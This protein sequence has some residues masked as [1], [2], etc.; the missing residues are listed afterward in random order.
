M[1]A[2][3]KRNIILDNYQNPSNKG[4]PD[5][6]DKSYTKVNSRNESCIDNI[7]VAAKI[8]NEKLEDIKF[9]G[10]ACAICTSCTSVMTKQFKGKTLEEAK[11]I[12]TNFENMINEQPYNPEI[13]GEFNI[14]DEI[15]KQPSRKKC[16]LLP[17]EAIKK[18]IQNDNNRS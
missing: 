9:D 17:I 7:D 14:Y 1:D 8:N 4:L 13:L 5:S 2:N 11:E 6:N 3:V 16:A 10:E 18:I 15:Y 12:V